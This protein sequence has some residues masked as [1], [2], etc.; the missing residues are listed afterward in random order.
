MIAL[1]V[2]DGILK[3]L[4]GVSKDVLFEDTEAYEYRIQS[5]I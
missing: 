1:G 5:F 4:H 2:D 3:V